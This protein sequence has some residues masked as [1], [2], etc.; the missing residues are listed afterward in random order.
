MPNRVRPL[1]YSRTLQ[2]RPYQGNHPMALD[3]IPLF[4]ALKSKMNW[5]QARQNLLA[6]NVANADTPGFEGRDLVPFK[7]DAPRSGELLSPVGV[8]RTNIEHIRGTILAEARANF[9]SDDGPGWE[10]TPVGNGVTLEEQ[11]MK[12]TGNAY[13]YQVASAL[14]SRS[15]GILKTA[16]RGKV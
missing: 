6:E 1:P 13:D 9:G 2:H 11:M 8:A 12:V 3:S 4:A 15:L 16:L 5:H 10:V 14:Y 7:V